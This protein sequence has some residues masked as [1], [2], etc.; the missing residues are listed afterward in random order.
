MRAAEVNV[1]ETQLA[2]PV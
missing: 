1:H 2:I